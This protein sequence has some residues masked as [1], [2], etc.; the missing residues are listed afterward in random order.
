MKETITV[1]SAEDA[2]VTVAVTGAPGST[3]RE[4]TKQLERALGETVKDTPTREIAQRV[5]LRQR[6][7]QRR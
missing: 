5:T 1:E 7:E 4:L 2:S 6:R 3:C